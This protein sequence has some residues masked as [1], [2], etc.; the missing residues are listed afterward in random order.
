METFSKSGSSPLPVG[1][2]DFEH[3]PETE[4]DLLDFIENAAVPMRW[5][6]EDGTI[7]W[8][9]KAD[10]A[11][12]GYSREE[13][14]G[15][16]IWEFHADD[17]G[18]MEIIQNLKNGVEVRGR[19]V[20]LRRKDGSICYGAVSFSGYHKNGELVHTRCIT[21]DITGQ[22]E[23]SLVQ[24]RL[25][26]IVESSEDAIISK[27][28]NGI[29]QSWNASAE[30]IFGYKAE[31]MIG[32]HI[33]VIAPPD[34]KEEIS[35]ILSRIARG[36]SV[37][38]FETKR[39]AKDGRILDV[40]LTVSPVRNAFGQIMGASKIARDITEQKRLSSLQERL[41]AIVQSS[42]DAIISH[43]LHG[44]I[45]SWNGGAQRLFGYTAQEIIGKPLSV[46]APPDRVDEMP[47]NLARIVRGESVDHYQTLRRTKDGRILTVSLTISP[48]RDSTGVIV[49]ASK[50]IRD[51][52]E[53]EQYER[54]LREANVAL[55]RSNTDLQQF[56]YSASHDLQE[57][58]RMVSTYSDLL[59][60][61]FGDKLGPE[62]A[63]YIGYTTQGARRMEQLLKD[64]RTYTLA[65]TLESKPPEEVDANAALKQALQGLE[66]AIRDSEATISSTPLPSV[67]IRGFE[68]QQIFQNLIGNSIRFR[69]IDP[70]TIHVTAEQADEEWV[71]SVT[72]NGIGIEPQYKEQIFGLFTRLHSAS[73]YPGTGMGLAICKRIVERIGG[74]IWVESRPGRSSTFY[75]TI[76]ITGD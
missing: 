22:K 74:R 3:T 34:R 51:I 33:S 69:R 17:P 27:D 19:E 64:L 12:L 70:L 14:V 36:E 47:S 4:T 5:L 62:G 8:A 20:R 16:N 50:V 10:L 71:F 56:A 31:E 7:L 9:N 45:E 68:L 26:A 76:P 24:Q 21:I 75:F 30:R 41:A 28:L 2:R 29:V 67:R 1:F 72:D 38:H 39:I 57:P 35:E 15:H 25:S 73:Q 58:L 61:D 60:R 32:K 53:R 6:A 48:V 46:L 11:L 59:M 63:E 49:G 55:V 65:S 66:V 52:T 23:H 13:Y 18:V 37:Q 40:A 43:D 44:I 54:S 42:D